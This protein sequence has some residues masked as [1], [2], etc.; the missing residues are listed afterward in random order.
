VEGLYKRG[1]VRAGTSDANRAF[2]RV[3]AA[4]NPST[5]AEGVQIRRLSQVERTT[6]NLRDEKLKTAR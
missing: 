6:A 3:G 1:R 2:Q 4:I 5:G